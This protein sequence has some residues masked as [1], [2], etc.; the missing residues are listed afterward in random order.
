MLKHE[1]MVENN[2]DII[3]KNY[4]VIQSQEDYPL[5]IY[6]SDNMPL[7]IEIVLN[8]CDG[9]ISDD[10]SCAIS[11]L[12]SDKIDIDKKKCYAKCLSTIINNITAVSYTHLNCRY[13]NSRYVG[14]T[15]S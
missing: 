11:L 3:H 7:Y 2:S 10:E 6:I 13:T 12:N 5:K 1:N 14:F 8:N 4:T 9:Y 15:Y